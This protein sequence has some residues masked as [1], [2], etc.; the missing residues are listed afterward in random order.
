MLTPEQVERIAVTFFKGYIYGLL[1]HAG[2][3]ELCEC[4][5]TVCFS[6]CDVCVCL[7]GPRCVLDKQKVRCL[8][9]CLRR[10]KGVCGFGAIV[11]IFLKRFGFYL[12]WGIAVYEFRRLWCI[13]RLSCWCLLD[14]TFHCFGFESQHFFEWR[15]RCFVAFLE[16]LKRFSVSIGC[17]HFSKF[18]L[19]GID[20]NINTIEIIEKKPICAY[21]F[22]VFWGCGIHR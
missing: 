3:L 18:R 15:Y 8:L 22:S 2:M 10:K 21:R 11:S 12:R 5:F 4:P 20:G 13:A 7:T 14:G 16:I 19:I 6:L 17:K 1:C 9:R